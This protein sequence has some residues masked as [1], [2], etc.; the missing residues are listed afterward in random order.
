MFLCLMRKA[1]SPL[2]CSWA[3]STAKSLLELR[4]LYSALRRG[5]SLSFLIWFLMVSTPVVIFGI[6]ALADG[7]CGELS[8]QEA[9][10]WRVSSGHS[11][12]GRD[13]S[14][15]ATT[16]EQHHGGQGHCVKDREVREPQDNVAWQGSRKECV[17]WCKLQGGFGTVAIEIGYLGGVET[18]LNVTSS[19][20]LCVT[21]NEPCNEQCKPACGRG[22][23]EPQSDTAWLCDTRQGWSVRL[24]FGCRERL[25]SRMSTATAESRYSSVDVQQ[26]QEIDTCRNAATTLEIDVMMSV[27]PNLWCLDL[28]PAPRAGRC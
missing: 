7:R 27:Q 6:V 26:E 11:R 25:I 15:V 5:E 3:S 13:E 4:Y 14:A 10:Y 20:S 22:A 17:S 28:N 8:L 1:M 18:I 24:P 23:T 9:M 12:G 19:S 2:W 21:S 16:T